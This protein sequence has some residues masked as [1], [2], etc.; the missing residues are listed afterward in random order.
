MR[1]EINLHLACAVQ[2]RMHTLIEHV[3]ADALPSLRRGVSKHQRYGGL[4][5]TGRAQQQVARTPVQAAT[6]QPVELGIAARKQSPL[7]RLYMLRRHE[8]WED[9]QTA[10]LDDVV[11]SAL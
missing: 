3:I 9:R 7:E 4:A 6:D 1:S 2:Q 11:V 8:P 10:A 5:R